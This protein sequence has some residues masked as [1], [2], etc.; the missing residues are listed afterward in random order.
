MTE[1]LLPCPWCKVEPAIWTAEGGSMPLMGAAGFYIGH[2]TNLDR[3]PFVRPAWYRT[4]AEAIAAW[5]RRAP[6]AGAGWVR[7]EDRLP[8]PFKIDTYGLRVM[9]AGSG[10]A[11]ADYIF[12]AGAEGWGFYLCG[13]SRCRVSAT[14]WRE[15]PEPPEPK[16]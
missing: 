2:S 9:L 7:C 3:C 10:M 15:K 13:P 8:D 4:K 5:N 14:H 1:K 11:V 16:P 6:G 12:P